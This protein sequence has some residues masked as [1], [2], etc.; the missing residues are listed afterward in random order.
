MKRA[1]TVEQIGRCDRASLH[2]SPSSNERQV[3]YLQTTD[4][5]GEQEHSNIIQVDIQKKVETQHT[6]T[7]WE[8]LT[9]A[10]KNMTGI[11]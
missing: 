11:Y 2:K 7:R 10:G 4:V 9:H 6:E 8:T 1:L 5:E 3:M